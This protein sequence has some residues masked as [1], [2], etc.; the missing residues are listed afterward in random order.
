[1]KKGT[2]DAHKTDV[3]TIEK[4]HKKTDK[5]AEKRLT[6]RILWLKVAVALITVLL[7]T[8]LLSSGKQRNVALKQSTVE[9]AKQWNQTVNARKQDVDRYKQ[10][11]VEVHT[12]LDWVCGMQK[13]E[14]KW[15]EVPWKRWFW[16]RKS[17][18]ME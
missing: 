10:K 6:M 4:K 2:M 7:K 1:M 14:P 12:N 13:V 9:V 5:T 8:L 17:K 16:T 3:G 11:K 18:T 15:D